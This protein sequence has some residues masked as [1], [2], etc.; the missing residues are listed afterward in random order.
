MCINDSTEN[1]VYAEDLG[2]CEDIWYSQFHWIEF[3]SNLG[4]VF[5]KFVKIS[6]S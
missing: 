3:D 1:R 6:M 5:V 2:I 4:K